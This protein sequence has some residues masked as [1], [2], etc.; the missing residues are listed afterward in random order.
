M[1]L[2]KTLEL[3]ALFSHAKEFYLTKRREKKR[4]KLE[5]VPAFNVGVLCVLVSE[6]VTMLKLL[7]RRT[8]FSSVS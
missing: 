2:F 6:M 3:F 5:S 4:S 1:V 7:R 8:I